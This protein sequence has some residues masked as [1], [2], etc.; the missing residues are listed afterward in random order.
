[1]DRAQCALRRAL[2]SIAS[3]RNLFGL[4]GS[5]IEE[6]TTLETVIN[7]RDNANGPFQPQ[8]AF[9]VIGAQ[10]VDFNGFAIMATGSIAI[11]TAGTYTFGFNSDDGGGIYID[12]QPVIVADVDRGSTTSLGAV[13]LAVGPHR[14]EFLYWENGGG[15]QCQ[16]FVANEIGDFTAAG[17]DDATILANYQLLETSVFDLGD[18]D[19]DGI[20]DAYEES[21]FPGDL[22]QLGLG[23][24]DGDTVN[25]P[26][27]YANGTDPTEVDSDM[28]GL[29]DAEE[30]LAGT[31]PLDPDSDGDGLLDGVEDNTGMFEGPGQTGTDP[32]NADSDG[33]GWNDG[34]EVNWPSDPT[35]DTSFPAVVPD[36]L[37]LLAYWDFNDSTNPTSSL[38]C[39]HGFEAVFFGPVPPIVPMRTGCQERGAT[40]R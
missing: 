27:E 2:N 32:V 5:I 24:F 40:G 4:T 38:D 21:L 6:T 9:P 14:V 35:M 36:Q 31:N 17:S 11:T 29:N 1:M 13:D 16:V 18:T 33:D 34:T 39:M 3:V 19:A 8:A 28:D 15:A 30:M 12:G 37:N 20:P 7:F 25:D 22:T 26:E 10:D 23:D